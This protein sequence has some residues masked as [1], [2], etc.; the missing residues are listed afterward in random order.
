[1]RDRNGG[2]RSP[3][4]LRRAAALIIVVGLALVAWGASRVAAEV[5]VPGRYERLAETSAPREAE[6]DGSAAWTDVLEQGPDAVG[7]VTVSDTT[8]DYPVVQGDDNEFYLHHDMWG[9]ESN[10]GSIFADA[11]CDVRHGLS[12]LLYGHH[13]FTSDKMFAPIAGCDDQG[14]FDEVLSGSTATWSRPGLPTLTLRP[15]MAMRVEADDELTQTFGIYSPQTLREWLGR[16]M[17]RADARA[18]R[19]DAA[20]AAARDALTLATCTSNTGDQTYRTVVVF[21]A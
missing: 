12:T 3:Y 21:V 1:M 14:E 7:W 18:E 4:R 17:E 16:M 6:A 19:A 13:L 9:D 15:V 2:Q 20:I 11:R 8:I 10:A 5:L